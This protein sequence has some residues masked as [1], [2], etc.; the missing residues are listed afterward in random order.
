L[1]TIRHETQRLSRL[2]DDLLDLGRLEAGV[3][4]LQLQL[5]SL[6][7]LVIR[8]VNAVEPRSQAVGLSI[9]VNLV[10]VAI[11]G[12][13]ERLVQAILN[14]LDNAIKHSSQGNK[15]FI[16]SSR[17]GKYAKLIILDQGTGIRKQDLPHIFEQF[18]TT[19]PSRKG[20]GSGL[21]LAIAKRIIEAHHGTIS[22]NSTV[23][24]GATFTICLPCV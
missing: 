24:Q 2:I 18:Y 23:G 19:D 3:T 21:G 14:V 20:K 15:I 13:P 7:S 8:I 10:D 16:S 12:D 22:V 6:K 9:E 5:L 4:Q 1:S 17:D 11:Q